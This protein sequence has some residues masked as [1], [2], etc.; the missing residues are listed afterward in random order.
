MEF[1]MGKLFS[2]L[3][4]VMLLVLMVAT[5]AAVSLTGAQIVFAMFL[6]GLLAW[7]LKRRRRWRAP[8]AA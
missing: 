8:P 3:C 2:I 4:G 5:V 6:V 1:A 7:D